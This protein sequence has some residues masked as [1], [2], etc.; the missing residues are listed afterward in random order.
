MS[1]KITE[2]P[3]RGGFSPSSARRG[4]APRWF[5][6]PAR[7]QEMRTKVVFC[8][9]EPAR[10]RTGVVLCS[11]EVARDAHR[12]GFLLLR[13]RK[14]F[15]PGWF[16]TFASPRGFAPGWFLTFASSQEL[17]TKVVFNICEPARCFFAPAKCLSS[18]TKSH[19]E[20]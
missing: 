18:D 20:D 1:K 12:G 4:S 6:A 2:A 5:F 8:S 19:N 11:C 7:S 14:S 9:C 15:A 16:L 13:A 10:L 17:C 3:H